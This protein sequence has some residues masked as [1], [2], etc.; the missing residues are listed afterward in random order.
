MEAKKS[1]PRENMA[2]TKGPKTKKIFVGGIPPSIT[3]GMLMIYVRSSSLSSPWYVSRIIVG[4][5]VKN[6]VVIRP[7]ARTEALDHVGPDA[8]GG[9]PFLD[10]Q[11]SLSLRPMLVIHHSWIAMPCMMYLVCM[12]ILAMLWRFVGF[13][14]QC[15][16]P[17][18]T[19]F[20]VC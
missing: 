19:L 17:G 7:C 3:D 16:W 15:S 8:C 13:Q 10:T 1:V 6:A 18:C 4:V 14:H 11:M 12:I 20:F 9:L 2:A 5:A